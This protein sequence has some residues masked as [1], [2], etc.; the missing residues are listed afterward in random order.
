[1]RRLVVS[2][3]LAMLL[4][5]CA[6]HDVAEVVPNTNKEEFK[7]IPVSQNRD[8]DL[9]FL[10]DN[11]VSMD[12][13]QTALTESFDDFIAVLEGIEGGLPNVHIGVISSDVGADPDIGS[14]EGV[15]DNGTLQTFPRVEGCM[16]PAG[17]FI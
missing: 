16:P 7:D 14:C 3:L 8:L 6:Q 2:S 4:A 15:G 9:L 1:M 17:A 11:S 12:A 13:E 10:I 5:A